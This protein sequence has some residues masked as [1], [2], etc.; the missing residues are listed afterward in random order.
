MLSPSQPSASH[1]VNQWRIYSRPI[2]R[3]LEADGIY[4]PITRQ[5]EL[6]ESNLCALSL[7]STVK[8]SQRGHF[9]AVTCGGFSR[10]ANL[11]EGAT[12]GSAPG[13]RPSLF[14]GSGFCVYMKARIPENCSV[15]VTHCSLQPGHLWEA[16][17][18]LMENFKGGSRPGETGRTSG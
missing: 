8:K 16:Y 7:K 15:C 6:E 9:A 17:H 10:I 5:Q 1:P 3:K 4:W 14:P 18:K 13:L 11:I 2:K 12:Q